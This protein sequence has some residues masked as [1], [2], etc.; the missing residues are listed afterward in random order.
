MEQFR[1]S[2]GTKKGVTIQL[3]E[4]YMNQLEETN[5]KGVN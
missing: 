5:S 3:V 2:L 1:D 4:E